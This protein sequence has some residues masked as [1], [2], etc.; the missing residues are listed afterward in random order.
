MGLWLHS[1]PGIS[2]LSDSVLL[3]PTSSPAQKGNKLHQKTYEEIGW[4]REP[5]L[6][7]PGA[8]ERWHPD[9]LTVL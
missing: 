7:L 5:S 6:Y 1:L 2:I 3:V 4:K 9:A 8:R